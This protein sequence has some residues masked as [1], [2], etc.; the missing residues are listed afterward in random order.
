MPLYKIG[1]QNA[2]VPKRGVDVGLFDLVRVVIGDAVGNDVACNMERGGDGGGTSHV[3]DDGFAGE[4]A[5]DRE[6][7]GAERE[8][9][10]GAFFVEFGAVD[11][12][13]GGA[14]GAIG[15]SVSLANEAREVGVISIVFIE[16]DNFWIH[17]EKGGLVG[18]KIG[19]RGGAQ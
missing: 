15:E 4:E 8:V 2:R 16:N 19:S 10:L 13:G 18:G 9:D 14:G 1:T 5:G 7:G 3:R 17:G 6:T 11:A 12:E